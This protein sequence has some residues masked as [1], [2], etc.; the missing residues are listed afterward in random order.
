MTHE[1]LDLVTEFLNS[2]KISVLNTRAFKQSAREKSAI[3]I[4][5]ASISKEGSYTKQFKH[6]LFNVIYSEYSGY[7][8][9][10]NYY[11]EQAKK[12]A[13][14]DIQKQVI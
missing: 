7:L 11:L 10:A 9:E 1:D 4:N 5:I 3:N 13:E 8:Q 14:N 6:T 2:E 12:Y